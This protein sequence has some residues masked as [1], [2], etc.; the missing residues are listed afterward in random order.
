VQSD[1]IVIEVG[2]EKKKYTLHKEVLL[3]YSG[4]FRGALSGR[5]KETDNSI[6]ALWD[7]DFDA[8]DVF[9]DLIY[10]KRLPDCVYAP[11]P[12]D[13]PIVSV[14]I[15]AYTLAERL[16]VPGLKH[17]LT[18]MIFQSYRSLKARPRSSVIIH[19]FANLPETDPML[20]FMV[21]SFCVHDGVGRMNARS[22]E[23]ADQL[24]QDFLVRMLLKLNKLSKSTTNDNNLKREDYDVRE[25]GNE[26][27]RN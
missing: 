12:L 18:D 17:A 11:W 7:V 16:I 10:D 24:P 19:L 6:I 4:Y 13:A 21:D 27:L 22:I 3:H 5:F 25:Y 14:K 20:Q 15:R 26:S 9:V 2:A 8:F 23:M 1:T